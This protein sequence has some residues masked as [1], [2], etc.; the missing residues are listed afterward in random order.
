MIRRALSAV[1]LVA[2]FAVAGKLCLTQASQQG[3]RGSSPSPDAS[4]AGKQVPAQSSQQTH[5]ITV[6]FDYDFTKMPACAPPP[7]VNE[8]CVAQFNVYDISAGP[9]RRTKLFSIPA[10]VGE[11]KQVAGITAT[12]PA[13]RF[14]SGKHLISVAMQMPDGT[15]SDAQACTIWVEIP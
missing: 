9:Q 5:T 3:S 6:K 2:V 7:K 8:K 11:T 4:A 10:P 15:E 12:S 14:E 13:R 1:L